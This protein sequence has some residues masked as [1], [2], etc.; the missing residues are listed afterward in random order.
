MKPKYISPDGSIRLYLGDCMEV[1][2]NL[3][4]ES[5]DIAMTSPP[6]NIK[7]GEH[8]CS[9]M[10]GN[11]RRARPLKITQE[12]YEDNMS[13]EKYWE[14]INEVVAQLRRVCKGLVWVNH[15][16]RFFEREAIHPVRMIQQPIYS[17]VIWNRFGSTLFNC[18]KF[19]Q[20]HEG[21][22][23]FGIPHW[24]NNDCNKSLTVWNINPQV[25]T[26]HPCPYPVELAKRP[27]EASC[28]PDGITI[29]PFM[30]IATTGVACIEA[31]RHFIGI[32][33]DP[34][35]F[36]KAVARIEKTLSAPKLFRKPIGQKKPSLGLITK[37]PKKEQSHAQ[38]NT[39]QRLTNP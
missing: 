6:Y 32:E 28:P 12:W 7:G 27:I 5:A 16:V 13:E 19:S 9:G 20:S 33:K 22:W 23:G 34:K 11:T 30:G 39:R 37:K 25:S 35:Y 14:W 21:V 29:D 15:K 38:A 18:K 2:A 1:L 3:K 36:K 26:Q 8:P 4:K 17:E 10:F 31:G 24:W